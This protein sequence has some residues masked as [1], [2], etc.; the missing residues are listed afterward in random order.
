MKISS[1]LRF[2]Y[3]PLWPALL[4]AFVAPGMGQ[5][6]NGEFKKGLLLLVAFLGSFY[7]FLKVVGDRLSLLV[8]TGSKDWYDNPMAFQEPLLKLFKE[9]P[10]M[11]V[12]FYLLIILVIVY[13]VSDAYITAKRR[14]RRFRIKKKEV[15][16]NSDP[17][18]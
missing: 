9:T 4:S 17:N 6:F 5:I 15:D 8:P 7:W 11:F 3:S 12:L 10:E 16:P 2:F 1:L 14:P 18:L 13:S